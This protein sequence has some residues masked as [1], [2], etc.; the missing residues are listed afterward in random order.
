MIKKKDMPKKIY[1]QVEDSIGEFGDLGEATWCVD[2]INDSDIEYRLV[3][4]K[5][6]KCDKEQRERLGA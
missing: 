3:E 1:I 5:A 2:K 6:K 4:R